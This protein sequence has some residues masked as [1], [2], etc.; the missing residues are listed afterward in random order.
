MLHTSSSPP[1]VSTRSHLTASSAHL[2]RLGTQ[3]PTNRSITFAHLNFSSYQH[4]ILPP[5]HFY[6]F[7][8]SLPRDLSYVTT[9]GKHFSCSYVPRLHYTRITH[10]GLTSNSGAQ[11]AR[12][13]EPELSML[14]RILSWSGHVVLISSLHTR[15]NGEGERGRGRKT[16][17]AHL[18]QKAKVPTKA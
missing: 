9:I 6:N 11:I 4:H 16:L 8:Y 14:R 5:P 12:V 15:E 17:L 3:H 2:R 18:P 7:L 1:C 10:H 13:L